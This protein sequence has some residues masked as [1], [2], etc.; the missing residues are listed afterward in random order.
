[1]ISGFRIA[2]DGSLVS[3]G[4]IPVPA[5]AAGLPAR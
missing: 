4:S 2:D 5:G 1:M 3:V